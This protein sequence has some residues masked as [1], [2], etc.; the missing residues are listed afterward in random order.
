MF[1]TNEAR[2]SCRFGFRRPYR[3]WTQQALNVADALFTLAPMTLGLRLLRYGLLLLAAAMLAGC[4]N[5]SQTQL[6][7]EKEPHFLAGKRCISTMDYKGA[8]DSFQKAL[9]LNPR[10]GSAHLELGCLFEQKEPDPAAAIYHYEQFLRLRP[11]ADNVELIKQRITNCKQELARTVSLGPVTEKVQRDLEQ[12]AEE[13]QRLLDENKRLRDEL[14][15]WR[16]QAARP[17]PAANTQPEAALARSGAAGT[18]AATPTQPA[19]ARL[20]PPPAPTAR[21][22]TVKPGDTPILIARKY[23]VKLEAL[24]AANPRVEPRRLHVGQELTIPAP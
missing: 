10:S 8:I 18:T 7:E 21:T 23:G 3:T 9:E 16:A 19:S 12:L 5:S 11:T 20:Q 6:D 22:H 15:K 1:T 4:A 2:G 13:K 24:L 14:D 17:Q